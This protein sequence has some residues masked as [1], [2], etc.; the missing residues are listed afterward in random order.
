MKIK[1][2]YTLTYEIITKRETHRF[3]CLQKE[4]REST[5]KQL[6][7]TR[8]I[9]RIKEAN[10]LKRSRWKEIFKLRGEINQ[11]ETRKTP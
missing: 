7:N 1:P 9:S 10:S 5:Y 3:E 4:T 8:K 11:V 2:Q 6:E